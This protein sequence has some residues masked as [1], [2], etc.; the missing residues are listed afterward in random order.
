[1]KLPQNWNQ[2]RTEQFIE[3]S[4]LKEEDYGSLFLY[5]LDVLSI[6]SDTD[7]DELDDCDPSEV[8]K[9]VS[10][11]SWLR[12][13]PTTKPKQTLAG[14]NLKKVGLISLGEF[15]DLEHYFSD[16][17]VKNLTTICAIRYKKTLPDKWGNT[18]YEPYTYDIEGRSDV[19]TELPVSDTYGVIPEYLK[20]REDFIKQY[21]NLFAPEIEETEEDLDPEDIKAE[22]EEK[23]FKKWSWESIIYNLAGEDVTKVDQ[24]TDLPLILV[25]NMLS[26]KHELKV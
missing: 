2:L 15:I 21:E 10:S 13:Q 8:I 22:Q 19:F 26:M 18:E 24:I 4:E 25:F 6:V 1:M 3:L 16:G 9:L 23:K 12:R 5:N 7:I 20:F 17:Y 11:L 14:F